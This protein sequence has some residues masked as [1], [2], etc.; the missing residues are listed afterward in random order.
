MSDLFYK[1]R[2]LVWLGTKRYYKDMNEVESQVFRRSD[3][4]TLDEINLLNRNWP[5]EV[6]APIIKKDCIYVATEYKENG[7]NPIL[8]NMSDWEVSGGGVEYGSPAQEEELF[9]RS[10]Y[11][12]HLS[13]A[14]Y[15]L[16]NL[17]TTVSNNVEFCRRGIDRGYKFMIKPVKID[18][19]GAPALRLPLINT[20]GD[21][22]HERDKEKMRQKIRMLLL[23]AA[24]N[25]ND[26]IILSAWGCGAYGCPPKQTALLFKEVLTEFAGVFRE[27]PFAILGDNYQYFYDVFTTE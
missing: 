18:C 23:T 12:K 15:P 26:S 8:L 4:I 22:L 1:N 7:F 21:Y 27:T 11:F 20:D 13:Q 14:L 19:I 17:D 2:R 3:D 24:K 6:K 9:R 5:K 25:G 16:Y 10:N